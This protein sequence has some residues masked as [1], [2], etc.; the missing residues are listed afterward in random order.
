MQWRNV[1]KIRAEMNDMAV[2]SIAPP[3]AIPASAI[4]NTDDDIISRMGTAEVCARS[5]LRA[6]RRMF[7]AEPD[8]LANLV[9]PAVLSI[10]A[11]NKRHFLLHDK[12]AGNGVNCR[13]IV[14][15]TEEK[16]RLVADAAKWFCDR[17]FKLVPALFMQLYFIRIKFGEIYLTVVYAHLQRKN[18]NAYEE[19]FRIINFNMHLQHVAV[20]FEVA[21]LNSIDRILGNHD[22]EQG[23]FY[24]LTQSTWMH[25]QS[26]RLTGEY[27]NQEDIC[28][29]D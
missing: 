12:G 4:Q 6:R 28:W 13:V 7:P 15:A 18:H 24:H 10:T 20:D 9:V 26:L 17:N 2:Q 1:A 29:K 23:G 19:P 8:D 27:L 16:L 21:V 25:I 14:F 11:P 3:S 5:M 22:I